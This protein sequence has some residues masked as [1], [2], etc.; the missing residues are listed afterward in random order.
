MKFTI[1]Q[2][3]RYKPGSGTY[4]YE[5]AI[6]A[7]G[8]IGG[9]VMGFTPRR[10]DTG[11][12]RVRVQLC[13]FHC[14]DGRRGAGHFVMRAVDAASLTPENPAASAVKDTSA[15]DPGRPGPRA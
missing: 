13:L 7:D 14:V 12:A 5:D 4:G 15:T 11:V 1:G 9:I 2:H 8:R 3:V 10:K 6:E